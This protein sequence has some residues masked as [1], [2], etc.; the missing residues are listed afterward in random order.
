MRNAVQHFKLLKHNLKLWDVK[1][2][3]EE[4]LEGIYNFTQEKVRGLDIKE[5]G[6][7]NEGTFLERKRQEM[8]DD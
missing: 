7:R 1:K 8:E 6:G 2:T 5:G 3:S 4:K